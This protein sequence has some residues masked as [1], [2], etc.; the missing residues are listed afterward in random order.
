MF[1]N[2]QE[3][4]MAATVTNLVQVNQLL[5]A[6]FTSATVADADGSI[7]IV[8]ANGQRLDG[9]FPNGCALSNQGTTFIGG[10]V[11][12]AT[13]TLPSSIDVSG[14]KQALVIHYANSTQFSGLSSSTDSDAF[15]FYLFSGAG[16]ANWARYDTAG[17]QGLDWIPLIAGT[18][19][20]VSTG[21][22]F[23]ASNVTSIAIG[24]KAAG[25]GSFTCEF[26]LSQLLYVSDI[27]GFSDTNADPTQFSDFVDLLAPNSGETYHSKMIA[28]TGPAYS[29]GAPFNITA[30]NF[31]D[32]VI[33]LSFA[34]D[35]YSYTPAN[36]DAAFWE[37]GIS[38]ASGSV[39]F[40]NFTFATTSNQYDFV[41][42]GSAGTVNLT[43][44]LVTTATNVEITG[45]GVVAS[46]VSIEGATNVE[47][48]GGDLSL[49]ISSANAIVLSSA[50]QAGSAITTS[51][52]LDVEVDVGVYT[53]SSFI[54]TANNN[55]NVDPVTDA[56]TYNFSSWSNTGF[57]TNF[58]IPVGN[59]FDT[60][61][62][63]DG[64]FTATRTNPTSG[65]GEI[66]L[67]QPQ[68][69]LTITTNV[70]ALIQIFDFGTQTL[71]AS[72]TGTSLAYVYSGSPSFDVRVQNVDYY[73]A[74]SA[75]SPTGTLSLPVNLSK[76]N[77]YQPGSP[78]VYGV[79]ISYN[80]AT[81][82]LTLN[83]A[84]TVR[85][86]FSALIDAFY[87]ESSL[88]NTDFDFQ[89]NGVNSLFLVEGAEY[90]SDTDADRS[91]G[92][93]IRYVDS[94]GTVTAEW[95]GAQSTSS[96]D[97]STF[98][99]RFQ[100]QVGIGTTNAA[101]LGDVNQVIKMYGDA[102]HGNFDYRS[103]SPRFKM[104][105][106]GYYEAD[107]DIHSIYGISTT[108][109]VLYVFGLSPIEI[110]SFT[111]GDPAVTGLTFT[112]HG[113]SP[114]TRESLN[115]GA[116][117]SDTNSNSGANIQRW[118]NWN[119]SQGGTFQG[120]DTFN[121]PSFIFGQ[122]GSLQT[123]TG[124]VIGAAGSSARG[125]WIERPSNT[126]HPDFFQQQ[127]D[128]GTFYVLPVSATAQISNI[129]AGSRLRIYNR[130]TATEVVNA[131]NAGTSYSAS[132]TNGTDYT[133]GDI[134]D[135]YLTYQSGTD[136]RLGYS[137]V[138]VATSE[139]WSVLAGQE[140]NDVYIANNTDGSLITK[141]TADYV[142]DEI[143]ISSASNFTAIEFYAWWV[144]NLTTEEGIR[145]FFGGV[146][147][148]DSANYRINTTIVSVF[149]DNLT[150]TNLRQTDS[151]RIYRDDGTYP[152]KNGG[153]TTGGGG[154]DINWQEKVFL[155]TTGSGPLTPAQASQLSNADSQS[156][157]A[158]Q[159]NAALLLDTSEIKGVG[160]D[161]ATDSLEQI[162]GNLP[163]GGGD[164]TE[165]K[166]D[167]I[168]SDI[169]GLRDYNPDT[170][171]VEGTI[172][173][174]QAMRAALA[175]ASGSIVDDG[176]STASVKSTDGSKD[177]VVV[178]Y[179]DNGN[180]TVSSRDLT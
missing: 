125:L 80:R 9:G 54:F 99:A 150:S 26:S 100:L 1:W 179:D 116:S 31:S 112:N 58:D 102:S 143:D 82:R 3:D 105:P 88:Y 84:A 110:P 162:R 117:I 71:L 19:T 89:M 108:E 95:F 29:V 93:G 128:D 81:Q 97:V 98:Q 6:A 121:L 46:V 47:I 48:G 168:I 153:I 134:I 27:L 177:R 166:Q 151:P 60:T 109:P 138:A 171:V 28:R 33:V 172:T 135:V 161:T 41:V 11:Y 25:T 17:Y 61:I 13:Y 20:P 178:T 37:L 12:T 94:G 74:Y 52:D 137:A 158:T 142:D 59:T 85:E 157:Q 22:T 51:S 156:L 175:T 123:N 107:A 15:R 126:P 92:G 43:S 23:D 14:D 115:W 103:I 40:N 130:T 30:R 2:I 140:D 83:T 32:D 141:F 145:E 57:T 35:G 34:D 106:N 49:T 10:E 91:T 180:R 76:N 86:Q 24:W 56:G 159:Q 16:V 55:V 111:T 77:V 118:W 104:Q 53:S 133:A 5:G 4:A 72:T 65:G 139:G 176:A 136:A 38:P 169:A 68:D 7:P 167:Q 149:W 42:D 21:G 146:T 79:D 18:S 64:A 63:I 96:T 120:E 131:I 127:A 148:E 129:V 163:S 44:G 113:A 152:V 154:I 50:L 101:N 69:T 174:T 62:E 165:A 147:A 8:G 119:I 144:H 36:V 132:Y 122:S 114:I 90:A 78:L 164:A 70:S 39:S 66:T 155:A 160:F 73:P 75:V 170:D 67:T 87:S 124:E 173:H 45:A